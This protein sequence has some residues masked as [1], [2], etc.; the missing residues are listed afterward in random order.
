MNH[1]A[2]ETAGRYLA[3]HVP[4]AREEEAAGEVL[5]RLLARPYD[6]VD[7]VYVVDLEGRLLGVARSRDLLGLAPT[8]TLRGVM[9]RRFPS[10]HPGDDQERAAALALQYELPAVPV[11]DADGRLLGAVPAEALLG[12][13]RREHIEDLHRLAGIR[14]ESALARDAMEEPPAR[15]A[16]H[17]L[18]WLLVGVLG[19]VLSA[20]VMARYEEELRTNLLIAFF[21]P[22]IVY[23]ADAIGTQTEAVVVRFLS[24]SQG[25]FPRMLAGELRTG[26]LIGLTMGVIVFP[27]VALAVGEPR[28]ALSVALAVVAAGC[29]ATAIGLFFPWLLFRAGKD[30]AFGSGPLATIIQDVLSLLI[31]FA[32]VSWLVHD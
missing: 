24:L 23:L 30:P 7:V 14:R 11:I 15:R 28:L 22:G 10:V 19:S 27:V 4:V 3:T 6:S 20:M 13:L 16:R 1:Y 12:I 31:Y 8:D 17:R 5:K 9:L 29:M 25:S 26:V 21:V 18:P 2:P 32:I